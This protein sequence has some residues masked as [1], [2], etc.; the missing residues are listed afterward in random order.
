MDTKG[1]FQSVTICHGLDLLLSLGM[2]F[3]PALE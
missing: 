1:L 3:D 2:N